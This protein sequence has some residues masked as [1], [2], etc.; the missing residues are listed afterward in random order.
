[1]GVLSLPRPFVFRAVPEDPHPTPWIRA[2]LSCAMGAAL[3][4]DPQWARLSAMW[5]SFYPPNDLDDRTRRTFE[6]LERTMPAFVSVLLNHRARKLAGRSLAESM[7][8]AERKPSSLRALLDR[9]RPSLDGI[10]AAPPTLAFA[11]IGQARADRTIS[12][13]EETRL[14]AEL[15]TGW[16]LRSTIDASVA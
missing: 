11:V 14:L 6:G 1:M 7:P 3:Y 5:A 16:A 4:P 13:R 15:L 9:W 12:T 10:R 2:R 8:V